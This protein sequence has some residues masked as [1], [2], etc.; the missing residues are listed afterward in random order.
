MPTDLGRFIIPC[1]IGSQTIGYDLFDLWS[2]INMMPLSMMRKLNCGNLKPTQMALTLGD[3]SIT[4][5]YGFLEDVLVRVDGLLFP[6][7]FVIFDIL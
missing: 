1:S 3:R 6:A 4:Y 2:S 5:P 7:D